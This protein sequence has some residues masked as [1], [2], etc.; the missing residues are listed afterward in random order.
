MDSFT[1]CNVSAFDAW[2]KVKRQHDIIILD[3]IDSKQSE[4]VSTV[5]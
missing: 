3:Y 4:A 2:T 5:T 1:I